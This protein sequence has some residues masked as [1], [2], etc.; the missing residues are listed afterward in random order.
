MQSGLCKA[1]N[2]TQHVLIHLTGRFWHHN[3]IIVVEIDLLIKVINCLLDEVCKVGM[4]LQRL[5]ELE[6]LN[7]GTAHRTIHLISKFITIVEALAKCLYL[8]AVAS[9]TNNV[10]CSVMDEVK[11]KLLFLLDK[12]D[13][14]KFFLFLC[15]DTKSFSN[16]NQLANIICLT[17]GSYRCARSNRS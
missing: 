12:C 5:C 14:H 10:F 7:E 2:V 8:I 11:H 15:K 6:V 13:T 17:F 16:T 1:I 3:K 4:I 9:Q